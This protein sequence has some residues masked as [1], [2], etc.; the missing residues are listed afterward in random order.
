MVAI[1]LPMTANI[2]QPRNEFRPLSRRRS[3]RMKDIRDNSPSRMTV[4]GLRDA[5]FGG[6]GTCRLRRSL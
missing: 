4:A 1:P 6:N 3:H 5:A 2:N